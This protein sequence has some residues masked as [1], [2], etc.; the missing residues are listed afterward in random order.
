MAYHLS[1]DC[2]I[3]GL[4][5]VG[6]TALFCALTGSRRDVASGAARPH[7]G[8]AA[9]PDPRLELI[10][11]HIRSKKVTP[12]SIRFVDIPGL[13]AGPSGGA[14]AG[15]AAA[16]NML[17]AH[18]RQVD[19]LCHVVRCFDGPVPARDID[20][21]ETE[22]IIADME[23]AE[24]ARD[25]AARAARGGDA[26]ARARGAVLEK[27]LAV[28]DEGRPVRT[29]SRWTEPERVN[30]R[31]YGLITAKPVLYVAN[32]AENDLAGKGEPATLVCRQ[33]EASGGGAVVVCAKLEAELAEL[34]EP[35]RMEL[36]ESMGL[37]EP[38]IGPLARAA[39]RLLGLAS[40]YTANDREIRAWTIPIDATAPEAAGAVHS[41]MQ[42]GFI[43]AE[44]YHIDD[45][46]QYQSEKAIREAGK[47]RTEGKNYR[48]QDGDVVR[49]LFN[50]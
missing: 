15:R 41:D 42:R 8:V 12:A 17:L 37:S 26:D 48:M 4:P 28:L 19:A 43:R 20:A 36:L 2:G 49:F 32:V 7:V 6:K 46:E 31:S 50:V 11:S 45:L 44:C 3:V 18:I 10:S 27:A 23:L 29:V 39:Y 33:A 9:I 40:F 34:E 38:A 35:D 13:A 1:M 25:R 21:L 47:L 14:P 30:I 22:L 5:G 24:S 16:A